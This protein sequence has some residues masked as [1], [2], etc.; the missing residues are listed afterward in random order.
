MRMIIAAAFAAALSAAPPNAAAD[1]IPMPETLSA[2]QEALIGIW[3]ETKV[4]YPEGLG[5]S[6]VLRTLIFGNS[7]VSMMVF[8]GVQP[9]KMFGSYAVRGTWSAK[10]QDET[11]LVVTLDQ[12]EGRGTVLTLV[13]DGPDAF[14]LSDAEW[15]YYPPSKFTRVGAAVPPR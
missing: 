2:E 1:A 7:D 14:T 13:F 8:N 3:Q 12:G 5:H 11:T 15:S 10:R 4:T 6:F 9:A